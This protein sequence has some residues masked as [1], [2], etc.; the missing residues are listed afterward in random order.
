MVF[1]S[2]SR[3]ALAIA[4]VGIVGCTAPDAPDT[5]DIQT[6]ASKE[7]RAGGMFLHGQLR[8]DNPAPFTAPAGAHLLYFGGRIVSNIEVVQVIYGAGSYLPQ[9]TSTASP[10]VAT[11]YQGVLNSSYVDWLTEYNTVGLPPPASNQVLGRG[12]FET[13]TTISPAPQN[14]GAVIDDN[15]IQAELSAQLAA[16]ILPPPTHD[17]AGNNNTYYAIFF[18][19]GKTIT[20]QGQA[21]CQVFCAYHGTIANAGGFGEIEYGVHPDFQ[22]GSGCENGCG[23]AATPFGDVTQVAS[24]ELVET[25]TDPEIGLA[26]VFGPPLA[27]ADLV[28]SEIGDICND[29]NGHVVGSDGITYDVQTEFSNSLNDCVVTNPAAIPL[30]ITSAGEAC[31]GTTALAQVTLLGGAGRFTSPVTLRVTG[32]SPPPPPGGEI[33][34]TFDPDPVP[35]PPTSGARSTMRISSTRLTPPGTYTVTVQA[36]S[37]TLTTTSTTTV[38]IRSQVPTGPNLVSPANG[39]DGVPQTA[40]FTWTPADQA[41]TYELDVFSGGGCTGDPIRTFTTDGTTFAVPPERALPTFKDL[42]W[43]VTAANSCGGGAGA[44]SVCFDFRTASCSDPHETLVNGGFQSLLTSWTTE[45]SVPPPVVDGQRPHSGTSAALLGTVIVNQGEPLGDTQIS[46]TVTL[47]AGSTPVL[48]FWEWP[49]T[50]DNVTFDQQYVRVQPINPPGPVVVLMNEARDDETYIFRQ[51]DLTQFAGQTVKLIFGVHQ[52]GFGDVTGMFVDDISVQAQTCGPPDFAIALV[53]VRTGEV[54]AGSRLDFRV[55]VSSVNGPNFTSPVTLTAGGLPPGT[56]A[57]FANNPVSPGDS[58]I[59]SLVTAR[60]TN[61]SDFTISVSGTAVA[62]PP[63]GTRSASTALLVDPNAPNPPEIVSPRVGEVNVPRRPTLSWT[64]PFVPDASVAEAAQFVGT[65]PVTVSAPGTFAWQLAAT[66]PPAGSKLGGSAIAPA[67]AGS[68]FTSGAPG[69]SAITPFAFGAASYHLQIA[70]DAAFTSVVIDTT[71]TTTSFTAG[72]DLDIATQYFWRVTASNACGTSAFSATGSFIVG[73]CFEG[74]NQGTAIPVADG[75]SQSTVIAST[76]DNK[77]YVFGGGTGAG[78]AAR[79]DQTWAF[80]PTTR[81]WTR[82]ADV[83]APGLGSTF[84]S[85]VQLGGAVYLFGGVVGPPQPVTVTATAW[86]YDIAGDTWSRIA[87]LPT[88]NFGAA[89]AT[90]AGKIYLAFGSSF[91]QQTWQYDPVTNAYTRKADAPVVPQPNRL[92]AAVLGGEM[93]AFAGGF[94]GNAHVVYNPATDTWRTAPVMPFPAT[95]PAVAVLAGKAFVVGG[96][97][98][99]HTQVFDP[100]TNSWSQAAPITGAATGVDNTAGGV[101]GTVFH[102]VGGFNGTTSVNTHWQLHTCNFGALSSAAVIPFVVDGNGKKAGIGN[103]TSALVLNN[104]VSGTAMSVSCFLFGTGGDLLGSATIPVAANELKTVSNVIETLTSTTKVQNAI[105][106]VAL[107]GT[108]VFAAMATTVNGA[109]S[110]PIFEDG[111]AAAGSTSGWV[112]TVGS[113]GYQTQTAFANVSPTTSV[114]QVLAYPA[115]GGTTPVAGTVAFLPAHGLV[116]FPDVVKQLGLP[117]SYSGQLSWSASQPIAV[118][119]R[120]TPKSRPNFSGSMPVHGTSDTQTTS[121]VAYVEDTAA[122]S[123]TLE[124]S[125]PGPITSNVTVKFVETADATGASSGVAHA[126][127][128]PVAVNSGAPIADIVRWTQFST[129]TTPSGQHGFLVVTTPQGVTAQARLIDAS[130]SD[131]ATIDGGAVVGGFSPL[132]IRIDALPFLQ[133][134]E[135]AGGASLPAMEAAAAAS[136]VSLSRFAVSNP[137]GA[138]ATVTLTALNAT[139]SVAG[140]LTLNLAASGQYITENLGSAMGLPPVFLG[141]VS[142]QA[143]STVL[144]YNHRRIGTA[145]AIVPVHAR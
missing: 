46:Q 61:G 68:S 23:A 92:H 128:V 85:G 107:F 73:A 29:Q 54:C 135:A 87:D 20:L 36:Q 98:I 86:K 38:V 43:R 143:S 16:G 15:Q 116:S 96:R 94:D 30:V 3:A 2:V 24:H 100:A 6:V 33:T 69:A 101:L 80:D 41:S 51:F 9:V 124:L 53:P 63:A 55:A 95:D 57:T 113:P 10:S 18:P 90:I 28:F 77:L 133:L 97:P 136:Q 72:V 88:A 75:P 76:V 14:N 117:A 13:Q 56:T 82:K 103:E 60:P 47:S 123:S 111:Q 138:P 65:A 118:M 31:R 32:V 50:T 48:S 70:R 52:D 112:S 40:S 7:S 22:P 129:A 8:R 132:L 119:A 104:A 99:A 64:S 110:D 62:P 21:S 4:T 120:D 34:A 108:E 145:G 102:L 71:V 139:G 11:F 121:F 74:W 27:W 141:W 83:P 12:S 125:N 59:L 67:G 89:V 39:A 91:V 130:S 25:M 45:L 106:S 131:P 1:S 26:T 66:T 122:F 44:T 49:L 137:G 5:P 35:T 78:P 105:G 114:L 58:T 144:V 37:D 19:H 134:G 79:I 127:D 81:S 42:S 142:L 126:R 140:T 17:D 115:T 109:T 84:G 93:H